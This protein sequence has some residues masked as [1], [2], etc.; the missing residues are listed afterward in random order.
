MI[1]VGI[2]VELLV[3]AALGLG[4]QLNSPPFLWGLTIIDAGASLPDHFISVK[5]SRGGASIA[6]HSNVLGS[7]TFDLL[8][9]V[10]AGVLL[11][12]SFVINFTRAAP[13]MGGLDA[14]NDRC[15]HFDAIRF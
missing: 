10:P 11:G 2:G 8:V 9:A 12:G 6:C 4:E 5:A 1:V 7:N 14:L 15:L 13:M 3:Q